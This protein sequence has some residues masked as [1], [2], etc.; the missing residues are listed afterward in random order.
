MNFQNCQKLFFLWIQTIFLGHPSTFIYL[1]P[2]KV[3]VKIDMHAG[4]FSISISEVQNNKS[5]I[6]EYFNIGEARENSMFAD[7]FIYWHQSLM[8]FLHE[9]ILH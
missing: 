5:N 3:M 1:L 6:F 7:F 9:F 2:A 8:G 4:R